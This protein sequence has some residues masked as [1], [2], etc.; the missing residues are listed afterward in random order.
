MSAVMKEGKGAA[1]VTQ[2]L[3]FEVQQFLFREARLLDERR[4]KEWV[5]L[6]TEDLFYWAP[7]LTNRVGRDAKLEIE[8]FD[9]AAHFE[10][11]KVSL[12]N[13]VKRFDTGMAWAEIPPSRTRHLISNVEVEPI[14]G[15]DAGH[16]DVLARSAF[17]VYR[18]HLEHDQE[19]Y[20]GARRDTLRRENGGWKIARR[21]IYL[22]QATV[23]GKNLAIFF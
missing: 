14:G 20:A 21:E 23:L 11:G 9:G 16:T 2:D 5:E 1:P 3:W 13:R 10:D 6:F 15:K 8:K 4:F 22:D 17:I 18:S 7:I 12:T 19:I